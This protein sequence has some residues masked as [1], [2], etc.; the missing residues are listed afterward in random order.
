MPLTVSNIN[1]IIAHKI[2]AKTR[3]EDA[4]A[5]CTDN[6][7]Q[8]ASANDEQ[9]VLINRVNKAINNPSKAFELAFD[10]DADRTLYDI[11]TDGSSISSDNEFIETSK[12]LAD[13]LAAS[14]TTLS[15]PSGYCI[16][17][18]GTLASR[19]RF[20]CIIKADYQEVFNIQGN[21]LTVISNVFLSPAREFYKIGLFV[22][23]NN[24]DIKPYVY[25]DQFSAVKTDLTKYFYADFLGLKTSEN[26]ILRSKAFYTDASNFISSRSPVMDPLD[27]AGLQKALNVYFRENV[28]QVISATDFC[29][30]HLAGTDL[31]V[32]FTDEV[33]T[34]YPRPFTLRSE[35]LERRMDL[36]RVGLSSDVTLLLKPSVRVAAN[37]TN[38]SEE[39]LQPYINSGRQLRIV[40]LESELE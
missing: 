5:I 7:L 20:F 21:T 36:Q 3:D 1:R 28:S 15:I 39:V 19:Q 30:N 32:D 34:K 13:I 17:F 27:V 14:Q 10:N 38:P 25:D 23:E 33:V 12:M 26:D 22:F 8:Y 4:H 6:L 29:E 16:V 9:N 35:L 31:A 18:D 2:I 37:I 24:G 11:L 40:V